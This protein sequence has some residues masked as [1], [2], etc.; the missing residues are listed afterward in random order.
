MCRFTWLTCPDVYPQISQI[1]FVFPTGSAEIGVFE[2]V[3]T[4]ELVE[5]GDGSSL[6]GGIMSNVDSRLSHACSGARDSGARFAGKII[7]K[8]SV[9]STGTNELSVLGD[10]RSLSSRITLNVNSR[11]SNA[12]SGARNSGARFAGIRVALLMEWDMLDEACSLSD[13]IMS[14]TGNSGRFASDDTG[15]GGVFRTGANESVVFVDVCVGCRV[16]A[17]SYEVVVRGR[18]IVGYRGIDDSPGR[19]RSG[20]TCIL[21]PICRATSYKFS[22]R[23]SIFSTRSFKC[24]ATSPGQ[25]V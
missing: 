13:I 9:F 8:W 18:I 4:I 15:N 20:G 1:G 23:A 2:R 25:S 7:G 24:C 21:T 3:G 6:S 5:L 10:G 22:T 16:R 17:C 12:C 14:I 11:L 19:T